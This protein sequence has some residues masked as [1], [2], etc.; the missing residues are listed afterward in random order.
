MFSKSDLLNYLHKQ[1]TDS[2]CT[3]S[4][5]GK[6]GVQVEELVEVSATR[7]SEL[8]MPYVDLWIRVLDEFI[9]WQTSL[10]GVLNSAN[11]N[12]KRMTDFDRCTLFI[13]MKIVADSTSI[14][15]LILLGYDTSA[16][17][18]L[19]YVGEYMELY[20]A[21]LNDP[22]LASEFKNAQTPEDT[23]EFWRSNLAYGGIRKKVKEAWGSLFKDDQDIDARDR[24]ANW[25][26]SSNAILS[27]IIHPSYMA[28]AFSAL[29]MKTKYIDEKWFGFLG[30]KSE[31]SVDTIGIYQAYMFPILILNN[32]F[33]FEGHGEFMGEG[34]IAYDEA[35]EGH[36][37]VK[38]G[39]TV[40]AN[41]IMSMCLES[42]LP[43]VTP[44]V[45]Y[46]IWGDD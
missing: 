44:D 34:D 27:G 22:S 40:L 25:G 19:R 35:D 13:M 43:H 15:H 38:I 30:D 24:F 5:A 33:P 14:R 12:S 18:I 20:V 45:D 37:H 17:T 1:W 32:G 21:I 28:A 26:Y 11:A 46:S 8:E 10:I 4:D 2:G 9:S 16:R 41:L 3:F 36:Q 7:N 39:R 6:V 31:W 29:P 42:N 23:T